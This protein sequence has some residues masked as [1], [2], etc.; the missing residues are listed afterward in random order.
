M[1]DTS[2]IGRWW[3]FE[4]DGYLPRAI[5]LASL[6]RALRLPAHRPHH[7]I[8]DALTTA[9]AFLAIA[10][11]L[12]AIRPQTAGSLI[13]AKVRV[14]EIRR[15]EPPEGYPKPWAREPEPD[16]EGSAAEAADGAV[17]VEP[18]ADDASTGAV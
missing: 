4:R 15:M 8:G 14:A 16:P 18:A 5:S 17:A 2:V 3:L 6:T 13:D 7:A 11:H 1:I 9:Q 10:T 12:D